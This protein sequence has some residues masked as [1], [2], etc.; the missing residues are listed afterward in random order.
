MKSIAR[1]LLFALTLTLVA[2]PAFAQKKE[3]AAATKKEA[4]KQKDIRKL[5]KLTGMKDMMLPFVDQ[6]FTQ[7]KTIYP[8]VPAKK[9]AQLKKKVQLDSLV[10]EIGQVYAQEFSHKEIKEIIA[11]YETP[12]GRKTLKKMPVIM[13]KS[14]ALGQQWG[15]QIGQMIDTDLRNSGYV[16]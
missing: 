11:F 12:V 16:K 5:I 3:Q 7:L 15:M 13:Q 4:A 14:Q 10:D 8:D 9:W 1:T 2:S 6:M